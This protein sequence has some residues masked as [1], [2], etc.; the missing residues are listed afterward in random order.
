MRSKRT[1]LDSATSEAAVRQVGRIAT[2]RLRKTPTPGGPPTGNEPRNYAAAG[3]LSGHGVTNAN[4]SAV[5]RRP[6]NGAHRPKTSPTSAGPARK[7]AR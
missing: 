1:R 7:P 3:Y 5:Q 6:K 4:I 2:A